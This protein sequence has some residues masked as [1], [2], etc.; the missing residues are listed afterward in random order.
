MKQPIGGSS[1]FQPELY[2]FLPLKDTSRVLSFESNNTYHLI[3]FRVQS[4]AVIARVLPSGSSFLEKVRRK[5]LYSWRKS[6]QVRSVR[7]H[8]NSVAYC[9]SLATDDARCMSFVIVGGFCVNEKE[10][11][12]RW[13]VVAQGQL[14]G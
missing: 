5:I 14:H 13:G 11:A 4:V 1:P 6:G 7:H 3:T 12:A 2:E 9:I 10:E 8:Y